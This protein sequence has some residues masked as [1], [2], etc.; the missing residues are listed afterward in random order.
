VRKKNHQ[1]STEASAIKTEYLVYTFLVGITLVIYG[2]VEGFSFVNYD[3]NLYVTDN[4]HVQAGLTLDGLRWAFTTGGA[5]NWHPVT[6]LS[7]MLDVTWFGERSGAHHLVNVLLHAV[8]AVL[9]FRVLK[10]MTAAVW[11]SALAAALFAVHP[12]HVESVA[13]VSERKDVLSAVFWLLTLSAYHAFVKRPSAGRYAATLLLFAVG[14]MAKP[15]LV[16]LPAVLLLLDYWPLRRYTGSRPLA[17]QVFSRVIEKAPLLVLAAASCVVTFLV[18]RQGQSVA[19]VDVLPLT[20]RVENAVVSYARYLLMTVWPRGLAVFYPHP[21]PAL[22]GWQ[23]VLALVVLAAITAMAAARARRSPYLLVGWLWYVG[24]LVPVIGLVQVGG[25]ALADRYTYIPLIGVFIMGAWGA[26]ELGARA[27]VPK[28][29]WAAAA[30]IAVVLLAAGAAVQTSYWRDSITLMEHA[31]RVTG[32]NFLAHKNLGVALAEQKRYEEAIQQYRQGIAIKPDDPELYY[33]LG[34]ALDEM[35]RS[36]EAIAAYRKALEVEPDHAESHYNLGNTLARKGDYDGAIE[37]Y[38]GVLGIDPGHLSARVN[39]G[40]A[41]AA[42]K[43]FEEAV[44]EYRNGIAIHPN[45]SDLFFNMGNALSEMGKGDEAMAQ[46]RRALEINPAST[47]ARE[48]IQRIEARRN[49][50]TRAME[51]PYPGGGSTRK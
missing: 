39:L 48:A 40:N 28:P 26:G 13:W 6:W 10:N 32:R 8:A 17:A 36:D 27:R 31:L 49:A 16:T 18:Q 22:P 43:R 35:G 46:Y 51:G 11:P 2:Q 29:V 38:R 33:N 12:L 15:M 37:H 34:N 4:E 50:G 21:G 3:D 20:L 42:E 19:S 41:L 30:G 45:E 24:T 9:L 44:A 7:H 23:V 5:S 25:Q 1:A 14:L 47:G